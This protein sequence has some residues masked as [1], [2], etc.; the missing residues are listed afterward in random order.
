MDGNCP[1]HAS[2]HFWNHNALYRQNLLQVWVKDTMKPFLYLIA[3]SSNTMLGLN[4]LCHN[5][6]IGLVN[7]NEFLNYL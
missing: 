7:E 6:L 1:L 5:N 3:I 4:N 2:F